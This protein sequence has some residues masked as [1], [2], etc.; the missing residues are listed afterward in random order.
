MRQKTL[1]IDAPIALALIITF[2]RSV[3]EIGLGRGSGY[4]DS[5]SGIVFFMLVGRMVQ[6]RTYRSLTFSRDYK[7]YFPIA[8]NVVTTRGVESRKIQDLRAGD[9]VQLHNDE[10][11]PAD[12]RV[13]GG[14]ALIDYSFVTGESDPVE[15]AAGG[16]VYAGG[17]QKGQQIM[18]QIVK[19]VA[20]SYLTSLWNH[21]TFSNN[22]A[23]K[24]DK[25][26]AIHLLSR[27]FTLLLF[28]LAAATAIYWAAYDPSRIISSVSAM[29]I[30]ACPCALLLSATFTNGNILR[31]LSNNGLFLRD[32]SVIES[33]GKANHLV[34]DKTGTLTE[35]GTTNIVTCSEQ[36]TNGEKDLLYSATMHSHHPYSKAITA[37][38]GAR[39]ALPLTRWQEAPGKGISARFAGTH[40]TIGS[41]AFVNAVSQGSGDKGTVFARLGDRLIS[42]HITPRFR[43]EVK[44]VVAALAPDYK[45][46]VLSGDNDN[47]AEALSAVFGSGSELLFG[48]KPIDKLQY[49]E[50]AQGRGSRVIM[51]GDGL[52]DAGALQQSDVGITIADDVNNFTPSCDAILDAAKFRSLPAILKLAKKARAIIR[53]GFA[54]SIVYNVVGLGFAMSGRLNPM[55]A[56]ILMPCSTLSIVLISTGMSSFWARYYGMRLSS[57]GAA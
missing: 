3:Y 42:F 14:A 20:G 53:T 39:E 56:A 5:M 45:M 19:P 29:L 47:Q 11:I 43:K 44:A 9:V 50:A 28:S 6:E 52:N 21:Y 32:A 57:E 34:F 54:I 49:V 12:A 40:I 27:Y 8:V 15:I 7:S 31:L 51:I 30:V 25:Q 22:K 2:V 48:Q 26:S 41:A 36:L 13:V 55:T 16:A 33:L 18:L 35:A 24:N 23:E 37:W 1:N 17:K 46:A 4:L 38:L 10:I